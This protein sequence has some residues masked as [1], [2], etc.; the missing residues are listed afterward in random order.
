[1]LQINQTLSSGTIL[2]TANISFFTI[3]KRHLKHLPSAGV[4]DEEPSLQIKP[5]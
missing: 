5:A 1:M 3:L 2:L 4:D